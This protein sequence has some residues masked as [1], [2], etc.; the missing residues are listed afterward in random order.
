MIENDSKL[1][2]ESKAKQM[3]QTNILKNVKY[4]K[5]D[6]NSVNSYNQNSEV[7]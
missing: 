3:Q 5:L 7:L 6:L 2:G 4:S 1:K